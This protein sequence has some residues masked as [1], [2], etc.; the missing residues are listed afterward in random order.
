MS[1]IAL[2][3]VRPSGRRT[4]PKP[5]SKRA[6]RSAATGLCA[7]ATIAVIGVTSLAAAGWI[8]SITVGGNPRI[9]TEAPMGPRRL[10]IADTE[11]KMA[12]PSAKMLIAEVLARAE[13]ATPVL[14]DPPLVVTRVEVTPLPPRRPSIPA[15]QSTQQAV[16]QVAQQASAPVPQPVTPKAVPQ[17]LPQ[18]GPPA[19]PHL[20]LAKPA[21]SPILEK[22]EPKVALNPPPTELNSKTAVYDISARTVFLPNGKKLEAHSGLGEKMDDP[23][24]ANVRM[25]GVTPPNVYDL[26]LRE[27]LFHGVR[28]L[29]MTPTNESAMFGRDGILAHTYMLGPSGQSNGC[30]S[31]RDYDKFLQAFLAG[32][33]DRLVVVPSLGNTPYHV[34][35]A[36]HRRDV[37]Y[38]ANQ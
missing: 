36:R 17:S 5:H 35:S 24:F 33:I 16:Q 20:A 22:R 18:M 4:L 19:P 15:P 14:L 23:R 9:H 30:V 31:F 8:L 29:R 38:A 12:A 37:K 26:K 2:G 11:F 28:A 1:D 21:P 10:A 25:R 6:L 34:V 3:A 13:R 7:L 27:A 32:Q